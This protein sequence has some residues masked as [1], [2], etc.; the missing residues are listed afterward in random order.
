M[1][2]TKGKQ[3]RAW[4]EAFCGLVFLVAATVCHAEPK[5]DQDYR[6]IPPQPTLSSEKIEVVEFFFYACPYCNELQPYL[7]EWRKTMAEDVAFRRMPVVRRESW[8]PLTKTYFTLGA[9]G[10][11]DKLHS[12]VYHSYHEE[13][14]S[15]SKQ[16]V[17]FDWA[18]KHGL[19]AKKFAEIYVSSETAAKVE[20][21]KKTALDYQVTGTPSIVVDGKYLTSSGMTDG[22]PEVIPVLDYLVKLARKTHNQ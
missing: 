9:M 20:Q 12:A 8:V 6:L 3:L 14:L 10:E 21:A 7:E 4:L 11:L 13:K 1:P 22:V 5:L 15:M 19:D 17:M 18:A 16:S 2:T